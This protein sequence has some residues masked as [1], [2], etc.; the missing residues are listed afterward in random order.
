MGYRQLTQ[1]QRYQ[2]SAFLRVGWSQRKIAREINGH[3]STISRELHRN[4]SLTAYEPMEASRLSRRR[5]KAA[6][7]SHKR[8]PSLIDWVAKQIQS[9]WSP[10][11]IAGFMRRVGSVQVSQQWIYNLI[12]RDKI[13]G[14]DLWRYCRLPYQRRYQRHLA[15]R[16]GLGK[17]SDRVGIECRPK[18]VDDRLHIGHWEGD[19]ILHGHKNSGAVTLVERRSGYLLADCVPKLK[20]NLV[21]E[22]IIRELRPIRG[23]VQTLTLDNGSEFSDHQ[24]FSKALSL[25]SYFCD[26]YRSSQRGSNENTNGLLRQYFPKG[27]DFAKVSRKAIRQA[28]NRLNNRPRKRLGYRT[29]ADVFWGEYSGG[30]DTQIRAVLHLILESRI[31]GCIDDVFGTGGLRLRCS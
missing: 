4:R 5:R 29:P 3:S 15:K 1:A 26:P 24:T 25:T 13:A 22:V 12:Y 6:R 16:A 7:K 18:A 2:I 21:T 10:G 8:A 20:A 30:L 9:E 23:A 28:V 27:T 11:Q 14:G 19:T 17:I 31:L